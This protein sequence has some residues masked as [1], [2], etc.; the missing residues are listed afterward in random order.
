MSELTT[1]ELIFVGLGLYDEKDLSIKEPHTEI[2]DYEDKI[3]IVLD[4]PGINEEDVKIDISEGGTELMF[5]AENNNRRYMKKFF[6]P[7]KDLTK[8]YEIEVKNGLAIILVK[9]VEK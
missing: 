9:R 2:N 5:N 8:D 4:I 3:E 7:F 6:L 1:S